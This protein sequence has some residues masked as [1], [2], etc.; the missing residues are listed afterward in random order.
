MRGRRR[1]PLRRRRL[2]TIREPR[3]NTILVGHDGEKCSHV[4]ELTAPDVTNALSLIEH[5]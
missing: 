3:H 4:G 2:G 1:G 5:E